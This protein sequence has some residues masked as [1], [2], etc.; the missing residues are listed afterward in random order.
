M[1]KGWDEPVEEDRVPQQPREK[2]RGTA[3]P[4]VLAVI[5]Y[6]GNLRKGLFVWLAV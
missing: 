5:P 6:Q 1:G 4:A 2:L 3:V